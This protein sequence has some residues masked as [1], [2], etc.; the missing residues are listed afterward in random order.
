[1]SQ[2]VFKDPYVLSAPVL[3][4]GAVG[5]GT[6]T[7]NRLTHFTINQLYTVICVSVAPFTTFQVIGA[8]DGPIGVAIVGQ[9]YIDEDQKIFITL[10]QGPTAFEIGDTFEFEV[11]QGTDVNQTNIDSYDEQPQKNFGAGVAGTVAGDHNFRFTSTA[12]L[13]RLTVQELEFVSVLTEEDGNTISVQYED[14][15]VPIKASSLIQN[16]TFQAD[17]AG[18]AGNLISLQYLDWTPGVY[19]SATLQ[20]LGFIADT[21]GIAGNG[22]TVAFTTGAP[23]STPV[24]SVIGTAI[25]VQ[26]QS[27]VT[28]ANQIKTAINAHVGASAL[29]NAY[30]LDAGT[31]TQTAPAG[32]VT[33]SGGAEAIGDAGNEVV[34]VVGNAISVTLE[35]G[36]STA[37]QVKA[38]L[39]AHVGAAA[40]INTTITGT[41][42][43]PQSAPYAQT[44]LTGGQDSV[45]APGSEIVTVTGRHIKVGFQSGLSTAQDLYDALVAVSAV[46]DLV[47]VSIVGL[48][49]EPQSCPTSRRYLN[50]GIGALHYGLNV[51]ELTDADNFFEGSGK[52]LLDRL[53]ALSG[54]YLRGNSEVGGIL[55]LDDLNADTN[56]SGSPV[57]NV[58]QYIN[59][60][61]ADGRIT[62]AT[63]DDKKVFWQATSLSFTTDIK[64]RFNDTG[65]VNTVTAANSPIGPVADGDSIY[66][67]LNQQANVNLIPVVASLVPSTVNAFRI[68]TR[69]GDSLIFFDNTLVRNNKAARIG[70]GGGDGGTIQVTFYD[71]FATVIPTGSAATFDGVAVANEDRV[72]FAF[73]NRIYES[74]GVGSS[75]IWTEVADYPDGTDPGIGDSVRIEKGIAFAGQLAVFDG[76]EFKINDTVRYFNVGDYWE[77][78]SLKTCDIT[79]NSTGEVFRVTSSGSENMIVNLSVLRG[80]AKEIMQLLISTNGSDVTLVR[81][82]AV[83]TDIQVTFDAYLDG[84]DLVL[85]YESESTG[86]SGTMKY[87]VSRWS[88]AAGGPGGIPSYSTGSSG[89]LQAA[90][91]NG[92]IQFNSSDLLSTDSSFTWDSVSKV[93][94][95]NGLEFKGLSSAF[96]L[97]DNSTDVSLLV[98]NATQYPHIIIHFS[99]VRDGKREQG[100]MNL[101]NDGVNVNCSVAFF[102]ADQLIDLGITFD[103]SIS[104]GNVVVTYSSTSTGFNAQFKYW[105]Q[106]WA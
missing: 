5:D 4:S 102:K 70:E 35:G 63:V 30:S 19:A 39:D 45:G 7:V 67:L 71:P 56:L 81:A 52:L 64:I 20:D 57:A 95:L 11:A 27:G 6:L 28:T 66:V 18:V 26:I 44:F 16:L 40:L 98:L 90:G 65:I 36:V 24:V 76:T 14:T 92:E 87:F 9:Q 58:Q 99:L 105:L 84:D 29:I 43:A 31:G 97:I 15:A 48:S 75:I 1:M 47:T 68:A 78:S 69:I 49:T 25:S 94:T 86:T 77:M 104:G 37:T 12:R 53:V 61:I 62:V 79:D 60:L 38:A 88:D 50:S 103:A 93:L 73:N 96:V 59:Y 82:G 34:S 91:S 2:S 10:N 54:A 46:T 17:T 23:T 22:I 33:L 32:P 55:S 101:V 80:T 42:S 3:L 72:L 13:A 106:R 21:I 89:S 100:V 41:G 74:S 8:L 85:E 51:E 83:I